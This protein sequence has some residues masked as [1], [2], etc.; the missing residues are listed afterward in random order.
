MT[1]AMLRY[2][3][4]FLRTQNP[5]ERILRNITSTMYSD[6]DILV[7]DCNDRWKIKHVPEAP[8]LTVMNLETHKAIY[9]ICKRH[10]S[11]AHKKT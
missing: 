6:A 8:A 7:R 5:T 11:H 4:L 2:R 9:N 10:T 3:D 1:S